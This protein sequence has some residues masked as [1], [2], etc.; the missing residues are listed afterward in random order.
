MKKLKLSCWFASNADKVSAA[1]GSSLL[2]INTLAGSLKEIM[3]E[4]AA[5]PAPCALNKQFFMGPKAIEEYL[6]QFFAE[7]LGEPLQARAVVYVTRPNKGVTLTKAE[8]FE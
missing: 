1:D 3:G 8:T 2:S 4:N 5:V 6:T 7:S